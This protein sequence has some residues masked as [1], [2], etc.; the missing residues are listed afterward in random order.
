MH[1]FA[2]ACRS[3][4]NSTIPQKICRIKYCDSCYPQNRNLY[5]M[6]CQMVILCLFLTSVFSH[7]LLHLSEDNQQEL[8]EITSDSGDALHQKLQEERK[9]RS[10][11]I[12]HNYPDVVYDKT[13]GEW[14]KNNCSSLFNCEQVSPLHCTSA[15]KEFYCSNDHGN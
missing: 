8:G 9:K 10:Y 11:T 2:C 14:E 1:T 6:Q 3:T 4:I 5:A 7:P 12:S 15:G 13:V